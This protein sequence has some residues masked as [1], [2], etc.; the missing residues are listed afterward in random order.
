MENSS[1]KKNQTVANIARQQPINPEENTA[2]FSVQ[3][4]T[5]KSTVN[6]VP[7]AN[8]QVESIRPRPTLDQRIQNIQTVATRTKTSIQS[9]FKLA[10][11]NPTNSASSF[12]QSPIKSRVTTVQQTTNPVTTDNQHSIHQP[13][14][15]HRTSLDQRIR[16]LQATAAIR[17]LFKSTKPNPTTRQP[18][19]QK[20]IGIDLDEPGTSQTNDNK[21]TPF[22]P[23]LESPKKSTIPF[24]QRFMAHHAN[25]QNPEYQKIASVP[26][27]QNEN[28]SI[29]LYL[30]KDEK[31][32]YKAAGEYS[33][34]LY[35][36]G[37]GRLVNYY[38]TVTKV[39]NKTKF[40][41]EFQ[42]QVWIH[43]LE[44]VGTYNLF[45]LLGKFEDEENII[46]HNVNQY[47]DVYING[48]QG[49][50]PMASQRSLQAF[51][52]K[53]RNRNLIIQT[54]EKR[55]I[56]VIESVI[57]LSNIKRTP[58]DIEIC[59]TLEKAIIGQ[60]GYGF[61]PQVKPNLPHEIIFV[62]A[63]GCYD[64][65]I[66]QEHMVEITIMGYQGNPILSTIIT[67]RVFVTI[68]PNHLGFEEDDLMN[69]KDERTIQKEIGRLVRNKTIIVYNAKK[70]MR[71]CGIFTH[72][73]NGYIDLERHEL[74]RR[75]CGIFTNQIKLPV[76]TKK[77]GIKTKH[78]MRTAQRCNI[79]KQ[80]WQKIERETLDILQ[81]TDQYHE[82]DVIELQNQMEDEFTSI[83]KTPR[84]LPRNLITKA[85]IAIT[86]KRQQEIMEKLP[87]AFTIDTFPMKRLKITEDRNQ[88]QI[89]LLKT[90]Q[91]NG[92]VRN[93]NIPKTCIIN[94]E[95]YQIQAI[96]A[97]PINEPEQTVICQSSQPRDSQ[98]R[99]VLK[100]GRY[101][102][103]PREE[104]LE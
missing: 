6:V 93:S 86:K 28:K 74:L 100:G 7:P 99:E 82:Q 98:G 30:F 27:D 54:T 26:C 43:M 67:P 2:T 15:A 77:F 19:K 35:K 66:M 88:S 89:P 50:I 58:E 40:N 23:T 8:K 12:Q 29:S 13:S 14:R 20:S 92:E 65:T 95:L 64:E 49:P 4:S 68:N 52:L 17:T 69:G 47:I 18:M 44:A 94:G 72:Y 9:L 62:S 5:V 37:G 91:N 48:L 73:I 45:T 76:M 39:P 38:P 104:D 101:V 83:G 42:K 25:H 31:R 61:K 55:T 57:P 60:Q 59:Q 3:P 41:N 97:N 75:K 102:G 96:I 32:A 70:T 33:T 22:A 78:P 1:I 36:F 87:N 84:N 63:T 79:L 85:P 34:N 80:L 56:V 10:K 51:E 24:S 71:L 16:D 11:T 90:I 46:I 81:I 21:P 103:T 53:K